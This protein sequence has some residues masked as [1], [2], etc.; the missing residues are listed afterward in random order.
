MIKD[1]SS[2]LFGFSMGFVAG[3]P[4]ILMSVVSIFNKVV[5]LAAA[6]FVSRRTTL[7]AQI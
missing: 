7:Y 1:I 3:W 6:S 5:L 2:L 4:V